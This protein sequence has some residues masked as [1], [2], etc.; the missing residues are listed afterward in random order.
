MTPAVLDILKEKNVTA[1]F[2]INGVNW[3]DITVNRVAQDI[4]RRAVQE[5]C[6]FYI[7]IHQNQN[8]MSVIIY[9]LTGI[10]NKSGSYNRKP[11]LVTFKI[12]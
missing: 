3:M 6:V 2:F 8:R 10:L 11:H 1:T 5:V 12:Y 4:V 9:Y 7:L